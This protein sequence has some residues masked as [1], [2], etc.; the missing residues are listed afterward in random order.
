M[1]K[2][3]GDVIIDVERCKGCELCIEACPED[4]LALSEKINMKGY[5]Y[6]VNINHNCTGCMNCSIMCPD[7][8]FTV[9]RQIVKKEKQTA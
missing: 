4:T 1:A 9:Y 7:N 3:I 2:V 5:R 6:A 8:C